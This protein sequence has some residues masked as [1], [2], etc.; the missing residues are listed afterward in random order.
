MKQERNTGIWMMGKIWD[1][2]KHKKGVGLFDDF[3]YNRPRVFRFEPSRSCIL[4]GLGLKDLRSTSPLCLES[5][6]FIEDD[7]Q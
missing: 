3:M 2:T 4:S 7:G 5:C 6:T 1:C